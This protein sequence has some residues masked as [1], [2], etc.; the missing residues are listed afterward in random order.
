ML[1][2][3][4]EAR[5][6]TMSKTFRTFV[7]EQGK[8][9]LL[10]GLDISLVKIVPEIGLKFAVYEEVKKRLVAHHSAKAGKAASFQERF[11]AGSVAGLV[12]HM[13]TFPLG[14]VQTRLASQ[15]PKFGSEFTGITDAFVKLYRA[16]GILAFYRG[17]LVSLTAM[18]PAMGLDFAIYGRLKKLYKHHFHTEG[19]H[20]PAYVLLACGTVSSC[21]AHVTVYPLLVPRIRMQANDPRALEIQGFNKTMFCYLRDIYREEGLRKG[22]YRGLTPSLSKVVPAVS[23]SYFF[24]ERISQYLLNRDK[25]Q[26]F[27]GDESSKKSS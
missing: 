15:K 21:V 1:L 17:M 20:P 19:K 6:E 12:S 4:H 13:V 24:Y 5:F 9:S 10:R 3:G 27:D 11:L 8:L 26:S 7:L 18:V 22:L 2:F 16:H 14:V 23:L 25:K